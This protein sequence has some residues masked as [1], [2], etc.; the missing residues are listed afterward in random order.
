MLEL[1]KNFEMYDCRGVEF[2]LPSRTTQ[3]APQPDNGQKLGEYCHVV[4]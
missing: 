1:P 3:N 2:Y 4:K